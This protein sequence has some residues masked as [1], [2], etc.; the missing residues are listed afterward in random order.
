MGLQSYVTLHSKLA[1]PALDDFFL[2]CPKEAFTSTI[3]GQRADF[4]GRIK[5]GLSL[6]LEHFG[7]HVQGFM[8]T[9]HLTVRSTGPIYGP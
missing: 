8:S 3:V 6:I 1:G 4:R 7:R 9:N 5:L 2:L